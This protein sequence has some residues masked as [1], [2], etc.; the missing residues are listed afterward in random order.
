MKN[1]KWV[2]VSIVSLSSML[3]ACGAVKKYTLQLDPEDPSA[4]DH[5]S[6]LYPYAM[7]NVDDRAK[8]KTLALTAFDEFAKVNPGI[9]LERRLAIYMATKV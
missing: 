4:M 9:P 1:F 6:V 7:L 3:T 2:P 5:F 8:Y